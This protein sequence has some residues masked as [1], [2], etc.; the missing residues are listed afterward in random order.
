MIAK[1]KKTNKDVTSI[2]LKY[3]KE[4]IGKEQFEMLSEFDPKQNDLEQIKLS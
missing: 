1:N 3:L 4:E 2:L